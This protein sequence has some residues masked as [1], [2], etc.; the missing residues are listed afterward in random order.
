MLDR[1][2]PKVLYKCYSK[3]HVGGVEG[4]KHSSDVAEKHIIAHLIGALRRRMSSC[5]ITKFLESSE[6][7]GIRRVC[8]ERYTAPPGSSAE[9]ADTALFLESHF[10][11]QADL[12][13]CE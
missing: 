13:P 7:L 5:K 4:G 1:A 8:S 2:Q 9:G 11:L 6:V 3:G 10:C 12:M